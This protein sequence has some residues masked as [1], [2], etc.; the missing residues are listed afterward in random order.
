L[1][2][3][4]LPN[5]ILILDNAKIHHLNPISWLWI[6]KALDTTI[7]KSSICCR[8]RENIGCCYG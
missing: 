8:S 6:V 2:P 3:W 7:C 4:P 5:S 1:N